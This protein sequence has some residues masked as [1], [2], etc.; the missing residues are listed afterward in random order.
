MDLTAYRSVYAGK[1]RLKEALE[2]RLPDSHPFLYKGDVFLFLHE[3]E[4][5]QAFD[6]LAEE[7]HLKVL[8]SEPLD[9]LFD[10]PKLYPTAREA[11]ELMRDERFHGEW[12]CTVAQLRTPLLLKNLEGRGGLI[13]VELRR[14][15][16][17][18]REKNT[19][20]CETLY[21]YLICCRSLKKTC[22]ALYTHR[23]TVLYRI[24][25][26]QEDFDI[27][28]DDPSLHA[29]LLLGV[30]LILFETKGP[31]FFLSAPQAEA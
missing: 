1:R 13:S 23:N 25:R 31:D 22:D 29:D 18:D 26:L 20:Y 3:D 15:V 5:A 4:G 10:L 14:L 9:E 8:I 19:Q 7:F 12:V 27:P 6:D 16:A 28:L 11:L 21:Y 2:A 30:S 17:H 24:R